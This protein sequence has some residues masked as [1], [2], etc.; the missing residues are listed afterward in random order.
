MLC[1]T[2]CV[3]STH[4]LSVVSQATELSQLVE[5]LKA[6][7]EL[8]TLGIQEEKRSLYDEFTTNITFQDGRYKV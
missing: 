1:S 3:T 8:E 2:T 6:F 4:T 7:R 5:Q